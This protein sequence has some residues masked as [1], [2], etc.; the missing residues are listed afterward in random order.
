MKL[1]LLLGV[2]VS[3]LC[4]GDSMAQESGEPTEELVVITCS[5]GI[6]DEEEPTQTDR[7]EGLRSYVSALEAQ[8][9][10]QIEDI[11]SLGPSEKVHALREDHYQWMRERDSYCWEVGRNDSN[12]LAELECLAALTDAYYDQRDLELSHL[13]EM[14]DHP[15]D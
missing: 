9:E 3:G 4:L 11:A 6:S 10:S 1:S 2:A 14:R 12:D 8:T 7:R 15:D 13:E 5:L